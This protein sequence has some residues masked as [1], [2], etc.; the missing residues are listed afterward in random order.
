MEHGLY[1]Y[2]VCG[3]CVFFFGDGE[4]KFLGKVG[5]LMPD[6]SDENEDLF[7]EWCVETADGEKAGFKRCFRC[8]ISNQECVAVSR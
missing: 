2:H 7:K 8:F 3:R 4:Y 1:T 6:I 5:C